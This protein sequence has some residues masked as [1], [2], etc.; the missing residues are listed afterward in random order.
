MSLVGSMRSMRGWMDVWRDG[1]LS[2]GDELGI[3]LGH[4]SFA[5]LGTLIASPSRDVDGVVLLYP[6]VRPRT[7]EMEFSAWDRW[8]GESP[9]LNPRYLWVN[10]SRKKGGKG[11]RSYF[12]APFPVSFLRNTM[13]NESRYCGLPHSSLRMTMVVSDRFFIEQH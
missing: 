7:E 6:V 5:S 4:A 11:G 2:A 3:G 1:R 8:R 10:I 9:K 12:L 13:D